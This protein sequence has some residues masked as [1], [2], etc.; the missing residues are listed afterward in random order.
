MP[1]V[2]VQGESHI[3]LSGSDLDAEGAIQVAAK[4]GAMFISVSTS[5]FDL[6][7]YLD[8]LIDDQD[9]LSVRTKKLIEAARQHNGEH[10]GVTVIWTAQGLPYEWHAGVD[11]LVPFLNKLHEAIEASEEES[12]AA[13][14]ER[15]T[16]YYTDI[17]TAA[18]ILAESRKYRGEQQG[19]RRHLMASILTE[20]GIEEIDDITLLQRVMP[21]ANRIVNAKVYEYEQDFRARKAEIA[22]ELREY[23]AWQ[24]VYTEAKRKDAAM[25][26]LAKKA[27]G[28]R[29]STD[30]AEET[31]EAAANPMY[32]S[33][34]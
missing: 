23:P 24:V 14:R 7:N 18:T 33:R 30:L 32:V 15:L 12:T 19:K 10:Q 28:H 29:L 17:Q 4:V 9:N 16:E 11:W 2:R 6:Q 8:E 13:H 31:S 5:T 1:G 21:E 34:Y 26:F 20:A 3:A 27:D 25:K 22:A